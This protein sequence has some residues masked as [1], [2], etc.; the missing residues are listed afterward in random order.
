[1]AIRESM[2]FARPGPEGGASERNGL[3][4]RCPRGQFSLASPIESSSARIGRGP[5]DPARATI[6]LS[7]LSP[8]EAARSRQAGP[9]RGVHPSVEA[10]RANLP[11]RSPR[12]RG[13]ASTRMRPQ[14]P[15]APSVLRRHPRIRTRPGN[16]L[17]RRSGGRSAV[18]LGNVQ[19]NEFPASS[20]VEV[21]PLAPIIAVY[22]LHG[23]AAIALD[24]GEED[25]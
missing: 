24:V 2:G 7:E 22:R 6:A 15:S 1:M 12:Q 21:L 19:L 17:E 9:P 13:S 16:R 25:G 4:S 20:V 5:P 10:D 3:T 8:Q 11:R 23:E 18:R 14:A